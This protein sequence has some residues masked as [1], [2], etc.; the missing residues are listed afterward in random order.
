MRL[1]TIEDF[2]R[3]RP[4]RPTDHSLTSAWCAEVVPNLMKDHGISPKQYLHDLFAVDCGE[5]TDEAIAYLLQHTRVKWVIL[6]ETFYS[7]IEEKREDPLRWYQPLLALDRQCTLNVINIERSLRHEHWSD[8]SLEAWV[9]ALNVY[10]KR[11][12]LEAS[13][14]F[15][16]LIFKRVG[17]KLAPLLSS[18]SKPK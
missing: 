9:Q 15:A 11:C 4:R 1:S 12:P 3:L 10:L 7:R 18:L 2:M 13:S 5:V 17:P 8:Q 16:D 14:G 6:F